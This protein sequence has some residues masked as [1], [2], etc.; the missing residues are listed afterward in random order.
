MSSHVV[1]VKIYIAI[2]LVLLAL[3]A[4]TTYVSF[5]DLGRMNTVVAL[6]IAV[7]KMLLV[8]LFFMHVKYSPRLTK[9]TI[10]AAFFWFGL[11][12]T[13]TLSDV[14]TR[15]WTPT[16]TGWGPSMSAPAPREK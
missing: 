10:I 16:P 6:A 3:T 9:L 12:I 13:F 2:F 15:Q 8:I 11:L 14:L 4:V 7:T 1:S 5:I